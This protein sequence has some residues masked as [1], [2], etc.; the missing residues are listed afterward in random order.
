MQQQFFTTSK[1]LID[2]YSNLLNQTLLFHETVS[3]ATSHFLL[4][5]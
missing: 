3:A 4:L 1:G 5:E 2:F